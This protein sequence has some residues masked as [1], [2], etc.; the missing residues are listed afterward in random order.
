MD[1]EDIFTDSESINNIILWAISCKGAMAAIKYSDT[2]LA[3]FDE[4]NEWIPENIDYDT[5]LKACARL[6]EYK[7]VL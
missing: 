3:L 5:V 7:S 4:L 2:A 1:F 6:I